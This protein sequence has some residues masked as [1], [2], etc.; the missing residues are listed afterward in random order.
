MGAFDNLKWTYDEGFEQLFGPVRSGGG[1]GD[2]NKHFPKIQ[3]P[4]VGMLKL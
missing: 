4:G 2:L 3:M 1:G